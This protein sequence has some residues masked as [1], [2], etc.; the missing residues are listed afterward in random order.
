MA[1]TDQELQQAILNGDMASIEAFIDEFED[2]GDGDDLGDGEYDESDLNA[3]DDS[4]GEAKE[5]LED[6]KEAA[7]DTSDKGEKGTEQASSADQLAATE[8]DGVKPKL[9][10]K[11]GKHEI[12]YEVLE[13]TRKRTVELQTQLAEERRL[14]EEA[15]SK[16]DKN[17]RQAELL[18]KQLEE[19]G[20][21]PSQLPEDMQLTP[22]LLAS[23]SNDYGELGKAVAYLAS[24]QAAINT[25]AKEK[26]ASEPA[27][28]QQINQDFKAYYD[29]NPKLQEIMAKEGSDEFDTL[30]HFYNKIKVSP[31]FKDKPI[32]AQLDEAM[33]RTMRV[34]G[35]DTTTATETDK[36]ATADAESEAKLIAEQKLNAVRAAATPASPSEVG[37]AET[38]K[39]KTIDRARSA[40]GQELLNLM[41][42]LTPSELEA[43]FDEMD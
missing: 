32:S 33:A 11:D 26:P 41:A 10:S 34:F 14:R 4:E 5:G 1:K 38:S 8:A 9:M 3:E 13:T 24:K 23:I 42:E 2:E 7:A 30:D 12:P 20:I 25:P 27:V 35:T 17:T 43:L 15:Q 6:G 18:S 21:D 19:A 31:D 16:L 29:S 28:A 37:I 36:T 40:S 22:E 39:P